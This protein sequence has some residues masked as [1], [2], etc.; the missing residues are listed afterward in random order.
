MNRSEARNL[1]IQTTGRSDKSDL[2]NDALNL[3]LDKVSSQRLWS[4][5]L[6]EGQATLTT[7]TQTIALATG[8]KRLA[9]VRLMDG[10]NSYR[11]A[12]KTKNWLVNVYPNPDAASDARPAYGYMQGST[13]FLVPIPDQDYTIAYSYYRLH[14]K[15]TSD[16]DLLLITHADSAV[17]AFATYWTL[18]ATMQH[19]D[20]EKWF[21][22][23]DVAVRDAKRVDAQNTAVTIVADQRG[24]DPVAGTYWLDPFIRENP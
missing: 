11:I 1:V 20:A 7:G 6:T 8:V 2:I 21:M 3:A 5:L 4:D 18:K 17:L 13:L 12:I 23:Y 9:E 22:E 19:E 15:L 10:L 14:P 24:Q 16:G